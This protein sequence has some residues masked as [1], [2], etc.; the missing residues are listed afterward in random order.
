MTHPIPVIAIDG[1]SGSGK[2]TIAQRLAQHLGWH[3]LD[4]GAMYRAFALATEQHH[5][6]PNNIEA[7]VVLAKHLDLTFEA[8][9]SAILLEGKPVTDAIRGE[10]VGILASKVSAFQEVRTALLAKQHAFRQAPG[11]VADGRDMGT[12][13][14]P[15]ANLKLYLT[16]TCEERAQRRY[17]QLKAQ[18][19]SVKLATLLHDLVERDRRDKE[20]KASPLKPADDAIVIDTSKMSIDDVMLRVIK[21][22]ELLGLA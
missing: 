6:Q 2:G 1:P 13:V 5:I 4:S 19:K 21:E 22:V 3:Y 10:S 7:L 16:A 15:G 14:F 9:E 12:V 20:R 18:G 11:L 17:Q 8:S